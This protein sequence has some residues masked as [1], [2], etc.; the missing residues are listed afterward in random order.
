[1][2]ARRHEGHPVSIWRPRRTACLLARLVE[3]DLC[4]FARGD[5]QYKKVRDFFIQ[6][7]LDDSH[8]RTVRREHRLVVHVALSHDGHLF[9]FAVEQSEPAGIGLKK[10]SDDFRSFHWVR[11]KLAIAGKSS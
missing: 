5:I 6:I 9:S 3:R 10:L 7:H 1:M 11:G 2:V 8:S 4:G